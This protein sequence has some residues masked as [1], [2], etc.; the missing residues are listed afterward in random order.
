ME[1]V[2]IVF[3]VLI[4]VV[5]ALIALLSYKSMQVKYYKKISKE[6]DSVLMLQK[7]FDLMGSNVSAEDKLSELNDIFREIFNAEYSTIVWFDGTSNVIKASNVEEMYAVSLGEVALENDF[8]GNIKRNVAKYITTSNSSKTLMYKTAI[9]RKIRS[10]VFAPIYDNASFLGFWILEST[11][12]GAFEKISKKQLSM[13]KENLAVFLS[14]VLSQEKIERIEDT[15]KQT[16]LYNSFYLFSKGQYIIENADSTTFIMIAFPELKKV[17]EYY[18]RKTGD[19]YLISAIEYVK[20]SVGKN[21]VLIR[22]ASSKILVLAPNTTAKSA[23]QGIG[24]LQSRM[25]MY[26]VTLPNGKVEINSR[27]VLSNHLKHTNIDN[28]LKN[29]E[30]KIDDINSKDNIAII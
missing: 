7:M 20:N 22:Y 21:A 19:K 11:M 1:I 25:K 18:G 28:T 15:D 16:G 30:N 17:N 2:L 8:K 4:I 14:S 29:L 24:K 12:Q 9:E 3:V 26:G 5:L 6:A 13:L 27:F 23:V 10:M